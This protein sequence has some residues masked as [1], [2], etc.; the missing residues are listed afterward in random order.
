[1]FA[2]KHLFHLQQIQ[3]SASINFHKVLSQVSAGHNATHVYAHFKT[4]TTDGSVF[5]DQHYVIV[6]TGCSPDFPNAL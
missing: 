2:T 4:L 3:Q 5:T 1:M 6:H